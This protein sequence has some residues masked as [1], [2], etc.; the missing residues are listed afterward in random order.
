M[1]T[2]SSQLVY[3]TTAAT[4]PLYETFTVP[5][6]AIWLVKS[7]YVYNAAPTA[8]LISVWVAKPPPSERIIM[9]EAT[10][11]SGA[12]SSWEGWFVLET[13]DTITPYGAAPLI[14]WMVSGAVLPA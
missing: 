8:S 9:L 5:P 11:D 1:T 4:R 10:L 7:M 12:Y 3:F 14:T 2:R 13:G 6:S